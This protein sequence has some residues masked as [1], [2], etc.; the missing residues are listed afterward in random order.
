MASTSARARA[1]AVLWWCESN[2]VVVAGTKVQAK[3]ARPILSIWPQI[4]ATH[5]RWVILRRVAVLAKQSRW[6]GARSG[7]LVTAAARLAT[8]QKCDRRCCRVTARVDRARLL[9]QRWVVHVSKTIDRED[10][11]CSVGRHGGDVTTSWG[12]GRREVYGCRVE[13]KGTISCINLIPYDRFRVL[14]SNAMCSRH[15]KET[16]KI[17]AA[18][19]SE[20]SLEDGAL[21]LKSPKSRKW[22]EQE[23]QPA[24]VARL[25]IAGWHP[26]GSAF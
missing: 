1:H 3:G 14:E 18:K 22:G 6:F 26:P 19:A 16:K 13:N 8:M 24:I 21:S 10:P 20:R 23:D 12:C 17:G 25:R 7:V 4:S 15:Q 11:L 5:P 9:C 2:A